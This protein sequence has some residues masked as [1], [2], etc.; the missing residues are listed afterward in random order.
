VP[1]D[2][3]DLLRKEGMRFTPWNLR[4]QQL[5]ADLVCEAPQGVQVSRGRDGLRFQPPARVNCAFALRLVA[6]ERIIQEEAKA[7]LHT[8]VKQ[9]V[10]LGTYNCRRIAAYPALASEHS[11]A[12][13]IDLARFVLANGREVVVKRDWVPADREASRPVSRFLRRLSRRLFDE[14][15]FSS[16]LTPSYDA[17]HHDHFH[18]D[19]APY[20]VDGT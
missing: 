17:H 10:H 9:V 14:K 5:G 15:V 7:E 11:F 19:G 1:A 3:R 20:Q 16:V 8:R 18:L 4:P 2:C 13:A 12:N 6:M